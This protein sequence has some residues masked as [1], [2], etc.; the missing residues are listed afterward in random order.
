MQTEKNVIQAENRNNK[1]KS[2]I[3]KTCRTAFRDIPGGVG[4]VTNLKAGDVSVCVCV[5]GGGRKH[6][7]L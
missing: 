6:V 2:D 5:G 7:C 1:A 3:H 4:T